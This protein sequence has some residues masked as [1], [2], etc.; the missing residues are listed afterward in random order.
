MSLQHIVLFQFPE[1]LSGDDAAELRRQVESWPSA[2]GGITALRL[3]PA[4]WPD[5][6]RGYQ[7]LLYMELPDEEAL[8]TYQQ[9]PVHQAF[10][11][12]ANERGNVPL[13]FDYHLDGA[14]VIV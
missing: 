4:L 10:A 6:A 9:H 7:Y 13:A 5:R 3:G 11:A 12:W 14:A 2:I 8:R 1:A